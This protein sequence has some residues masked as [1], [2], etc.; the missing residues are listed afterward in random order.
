MTTI[1]PDRLTS[2]IATTASGQPLRWVSGD[3]TLQLTYSFYS[4]FDDIG[5]RT[6]LPGEARALTGSEQFAVRSALA[7]IEG[8]ADID[9]VP[10][11]GS[12]SDQA[13]L[14]F[15]IADLTGT[16]L[17]GATIRSFG[18]DG[19]ISWA[20]T[21]FN[22]EAPLGNLSQPGGLGFTTVLAEIE[23]AL[24]LRIPAGD[25]PSPDQ[26]YSLLSPI[27]APGLG[28]IAGQAIHP[29]TPMLDD[30]AAL[31][32]L[33]GAK[34]DS[35]LDN[36]YA[37][38]DGIALL[39]TITD[40]GGIDTL[41]ASGQQLPS[42]I[43]L[44]DGAHSNIG[45]SGTQ[46]AELFLPAINNIAIA[47]ETII[48]NAKGG[49]ASDILIGNDVDNRLE[50]GPGAD[51]LTG[52]GG[53]DLFAGTLADLNGDRITDL[54][55]GDSLLVLGAQLTSEDMIFTTNANG[56][57]LDLP[58]AT[59]QLD[60]LDEVFFDFAGDGGGNTK[61]TIVDNPS[62]TMASFGRIDDL[63]HLQHQVELGH[64]FLNP[65]II[66]GP[67]SRNETDPAAVRVTSLGSS[68]MTLRVQEPDYENRA[69]DGETVSWLAIEEGVWQLEDGTLIEAG[70]LDSKNLSGA[71]FEPVTFSAGFAEAPIVLS[72]VQTQNGF[73]WVITRHQNVSETGFDIVMQE[74]EATNAGDHKMETLGWMA[75]SP[76][77]GSW[78]GNSFEAGSFNGA[79]H[80]ADQLTFTELFDTAP[81]LL[82]NLATFA[83]GDPANARIENLTATS[84]DIIAAEEASLDSEIY[85][86]VETVHFMAI[87]GSG[88]LEATPLEEITT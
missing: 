71:G 26:S 13:D 23:K 80:T 70:R 53:A 65:I 48:E 62:I 20:E 27:T 8:V 60:G 55:I 58:G 68:D 19:G 52:E 7:M 5:P 38:P 3:G 61:I 14:R 21:W 75:I 64:D 2:L 49:L 59:M 24:G 69:H 4:P 37:L 28:S 25:N 73:P 67:L 12:R 77:S 31:Q 63:T 40:G 22:D 16:S 56:L 43:D 46:G 15:G 10:L 66:A 33:Y 29:A 82:A 83:G 42:L 74:E 45:R 76:G 1:D 84:V 57:Q 72:Q 17:A 47:Y 54:E 51:I 6:P 81:N 18:G 36:S 44:H 85:H 34:E 41:D 32:A 79:N 30:I 88:L 39:F 11:A 87:E 9:F 35:S 78:S 50:G 86:A